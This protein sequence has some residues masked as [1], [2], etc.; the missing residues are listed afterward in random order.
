MTSPTGNTFVY[1]TYIRT[2]PEK[3]WAALTKPEFVKQYWF[4]MHQESDWKTGSAWKMLF[5]DG[6][7]ADAGE[8]LEAEPGKRLVLKWRNEFREDLKDEGWSRCTYEIE[9]IDEA[10]KLT[11]THVSDGKKFI[12]AVSGGWPKILSNLKSLLETGQPVMTTK[13]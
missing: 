6:R 2:T 7:V 1:V 13:P 5:S 10:V 12:E 4:G 3:L 8:V 9:A 11:V